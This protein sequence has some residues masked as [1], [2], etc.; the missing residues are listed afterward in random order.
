MT[1][2]R[3]NAKVAPDVAVDLPPEEL[4]LFVLRFLNDPDS[5]STRNRY[6]FTLMS[7]TQYPGKVERNAVALA[8]AEA[9]ARLEARGPHR[10]E[11]GANMEPVD[12]FDGVMEEP[13]VTNRIRVPA[14]FELARLALGR[15][16]YET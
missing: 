5:V 6:N 1:T 15:Q 13:W 12:E 10:S 3:E 8:L 11:A 4:A 16:C 7:A 14:S 9:W 2:A